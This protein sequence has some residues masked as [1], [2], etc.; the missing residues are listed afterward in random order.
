MTS[1]TPATL[2]PGEPVTMPGMLHLNSWAG[3]SAH[4]VQV[5]RSTMRRC[6]VRFTQ[7]MPFRLGAKGAER[8]VPKHSVTAPTWRDMYIHAEEFS[9]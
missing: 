7:D 6:L 1:P 5:L 3:H 8:W 9:P 4:P 2:L